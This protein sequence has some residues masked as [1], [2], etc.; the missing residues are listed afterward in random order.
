MRYTE[1]VGPALTANTAEGTSVPE[2]KIAEA[3]GAEAVGIM[4]AEKSKA[5][6]NKKADTD[7][8][9]TGTVA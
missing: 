3:N 5:S 8:L 4:V 6:K 9:T 1:A 2:K 7:D